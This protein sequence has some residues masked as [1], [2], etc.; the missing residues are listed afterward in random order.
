MLYHSE[1]CQLSLDWLLCD[2]YDGCAC[3]VKAW[4]NLK[5]RMEKLVPGDLLMNQD[6]PR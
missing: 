5:K 6:Q 4:I 1:S 2:S 3:D